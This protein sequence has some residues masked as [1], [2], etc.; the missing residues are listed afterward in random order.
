MRSRDATPADLK[1]I[2]SWIGS[3]RECELWAGP[4]I[5]FPL[6]PHVLATQIGMPD[7]LNVV[8]EDG[9]GL[10]AFGQAL[11]RSPGRAHLARVIVRPD[12]RGRG[13]GKIL[14]QAL[15]ARVRNR[16]YCWRHANPPQTP[17]PPPPAP[18]LVLPG[19]PRRHPPPPRGGGF[20]RS[21]PHPPTAGAGDVA[22]RGP[23]QVS[24]LGEN[25]TTR[26]YTFP[27]GWGCGRG[28]GGPL[29]GAPPPKKFPQ[30]G[31]KKFYFALGPIPVGQ[32]RGVRR[33]P[34]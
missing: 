23:H 26:A 13:I 9:H 15:L 17:P 5:S 3:Q 24:S 21:T 6:E 16:S 29:F 11:A 32:P 7:A 19:A 2:A 28:A 27:L 4:D 18:A 30:R 25:P 8:L 12:A 31:K 1:A 22:S 20:L 14:V 34:S 33:G 10:A